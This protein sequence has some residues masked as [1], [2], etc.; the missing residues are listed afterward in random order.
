MR[1]MQALTNINS[2]LLQLGFD[3]SGGK[4]FHHKCK[5]CVPGLFP[6]I[7]F[8]KHSMS[9][10][11]LPRQTWS[12]LVQKLHSYS[13]YS[14]GSSNKRNPLCLL[15]CVFLHAIYIFLHIFTALHRYSSVPALFSFSGLSFDLVTWR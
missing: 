9:A 11:N 1:T 7:N 2:P 10:R 8:H 15:C 13:L 5:F 4:I 6:F 14:C 12:I 3:G